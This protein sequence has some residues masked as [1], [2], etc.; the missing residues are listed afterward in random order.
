M[1]AEGEE[2]MM[3]MMMMGIMGGYVS[4]HMRELKFFRSRR[5]SQAMPE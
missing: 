4:W 5:L 1:I 2:V 3:M